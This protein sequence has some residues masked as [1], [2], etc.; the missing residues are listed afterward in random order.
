LLIPPR[1]R[2]LLGLG[3]KESIAAKPQ[4]DTTSSSGYNIFK[5]VQHFVAN[6]KLCQWFFNR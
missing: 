3:V 1:D 5:R 6:A 2:E 4:A